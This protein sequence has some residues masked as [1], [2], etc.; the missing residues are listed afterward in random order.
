[1]K[2][3]RLVFSALI[4]ALYAALTYFLAPI[5]YGDVQFR[6]SE[7]MVLLVLLDPIYIGGLTLGCFLANMLSPYGTLDVVVGTSATFISLVLM[8]LTKKFIKNITLSTII[9]SIW[10]TIINGIMIGYMLY[11]VAKLPLILTMIQ[12]GIGELVVVTLA[13]VPVFLYLYK[14]GILNNLISKYKFNS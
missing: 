14:R 1:M 7:I 6:I 12:V 3:R 9:A 2:T 5:S 10:P 13:G 11:Y 8:N 4:A